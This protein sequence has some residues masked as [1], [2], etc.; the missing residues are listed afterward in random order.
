MRA[1]DLERWFRRHPTQVSSGDIWRWQAACAA[2]REL[3]DEAM[4]KR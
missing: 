2:L 1:D 4:P 3:I